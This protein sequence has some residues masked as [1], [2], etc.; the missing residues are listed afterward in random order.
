MVQLVVCFQCVWKQSVGKLGY[1]S[2]RV[3]CLP[4]EPGLY[5]AETADCSWS[6]VVGGSGSSQLLLT[7][8]LRG[9][10]VC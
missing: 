10:A 9:S 2:L 6:S 4:E 3:R 8:P 7:P 1:V 5:W